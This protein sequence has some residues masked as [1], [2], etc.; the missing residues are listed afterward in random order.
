MT[1]I[2]SKQIRQ[3]VIVP[4]LKIADLW[5]DA[6]EILV[7]GTGMVESN[8]EYIM[9]IGAPVDGGL[10][11]WQMEPSDFADLSKWIKFQ[12]TK[13][14]LNN[15][16]A[17]SYYDHL[18]SDPQTLVSNMKFACLMCRLHYYRVPYPLPSANDAAGMAEWHKQYYNS[19]L[20]AADVA[21]NT[22]IFQGI[23]DGH[24]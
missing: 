7:Y 5:T 22:D 20:G 4:A 12:K 24:L 1:S 3:Y 16:L 10:G 15:L 9:Q 2:L 21:K 19:A 6:A 13:P 17:A 11:F 23:I 14:L 18:P 8:Y